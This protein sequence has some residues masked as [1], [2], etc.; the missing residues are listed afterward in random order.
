MV[1]N[2]V[3]I[4]GVLTVLMLGGFILLMRR[5]EKM[6]PPMEGHA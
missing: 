5:Q 4:G 3:R 2:L 6:H 1:M